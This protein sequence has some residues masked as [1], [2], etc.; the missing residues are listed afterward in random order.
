MMAQANQSPLRQ[1]IA[2]AQRDKLS[3]IPCTRRDTGEGLWLVKSRSQTDT[4]YL[5]TR[6]DGHIRCQCPVARHGQVCVHAAAVY[7]LLK[8]AQRSNPPTHELRA[9]EE[10]NRRE[11]ALRRERALLWADDKPFSIWKS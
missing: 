1:A 6:T 2:S 7:L 9:Q 3:P 4:Y 10:R 11:E 5:V 8:Q